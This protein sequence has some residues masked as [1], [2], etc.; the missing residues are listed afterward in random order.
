[1]RDFAVTS[2]RPCKLLAIPQRFESPVHEIPLKI[3]AK[4]AAKIASVKAN[5]S[6][7]HSIVCTD[8]VGLFSRKV[9]L[10]VFCIRCLFLF[11][12]DTS[13]A[14]EN[15]TYILKQSAIYRVLSLSV[16][17]LGDQRFIRTDGIGFISN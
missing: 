12:C 9:N 11:L 4:I 1:M 17:V 6:A 10:K 7:I 5:E 13:T 3:A 15:L 14:S 16:K 8:Y 2:T